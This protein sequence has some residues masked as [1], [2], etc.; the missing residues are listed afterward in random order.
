MTN[1]DEDWGAFGDFEGDNN[2]D[3]KSDKSDGND[4]WGNFGDFEDGGADTQKEEKKD[5]KDDDDGFGD[6]GDFEESPTIKFDDK[7]KK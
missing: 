3:K 6:F 5:N 1:K 2:N 7:E 4:E